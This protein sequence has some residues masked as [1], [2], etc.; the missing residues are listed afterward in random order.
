MVGYVGN[1]NIPGVIEFLINRIPKCNRYFSLFAGGAGLEK[2]IYTQEAYFQC[3]EKDTS[4]HGYFSD[5]NCL[6]TYN[7]YQELIQDNVFT[8][9]D[10]IFADPPYLFSTRLNRNKYY[11]YEFFYPEHIEFLNYMRSLNNLELKQKPKIMITHPK[12][13]LYEKNLKGWS[14]VEFEY[15]TRNGIFKD[16][17]WLNYDPSELQLLNYNALGKNFIERQAIK[18]QRNNI[19]KKFK[20]MELHKRLALIEALKK[21]NLL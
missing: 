21:E 18:R 15:M 2:S 4:L 19:I 17:L 16:C 11:K 13:D 10:F 9:D 12:C 20:N 1:K 6:I 14:I 7:S 3:A 8:S 5:E